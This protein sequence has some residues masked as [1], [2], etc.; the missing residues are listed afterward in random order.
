MWGSNGSGGVGTKSTMIK[1]KD[2]QQS[3]GGVGQ[4]HQKTNY[5]E[6]MGMVAGHRDDLWQLVTQLQQLESHGNK[7]NGNEWYEFFL[8][9]SVNGINNETIQ[10]RKCE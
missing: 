2:I 3:N 9:S 10:R 6:K 8:F 5:A 7:E 4:W 1:G